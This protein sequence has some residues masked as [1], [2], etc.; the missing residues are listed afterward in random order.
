MFDKVV[1]LNIDA[2]HNSA[3]LFPVARKRGYGCICFKMAAKSQGKQCAY[4]GC[5]NRMYDANGNRTRFTFFS[6]PRGKKIRRVWENRMSRKS[7]KDGFVITNATRVCNVHFQQSDI[8]RVPG[9]SRLRLKIGTLPLKWN[10]RPA[11][12]QRK[13]KAPKN[14]SQPSNI[15]YESAE[16]R[17][18]F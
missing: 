7:G 16:L 4:F 18:G 13:R 2:L 1:K 12:E 8:V 17:S 5:S 9:G 10:Q 11:G 6:I 15:L 14:R 3:F